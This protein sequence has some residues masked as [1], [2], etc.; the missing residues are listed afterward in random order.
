MT[1]LLVAEAIDGTAEKSN[2]E[3]R[4]GEEVVML[5]FK[6]FEWSSWLKIPKGL[7]VSGATLRVRRVLAR[8]VLASRPWRV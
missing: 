5:R 6:M 4:G 2:Q 1:Q 7:K 8:R 3:I